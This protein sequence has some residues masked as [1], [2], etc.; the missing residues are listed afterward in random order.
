MENVTHTLTGLMLARAGLNRF[1]PHAAWIMAVA[2]N[3]P[4]IDIVSALG[5]ALNYLHWHRHFTHAIVTIPLTALLPVLVMRLFGPLPWMR[6][7]AIS[8]V[9]VA[10]H[11]LLDWTNIYGIRLLL[12][13]SDRWL[14][15]DVTNVVDFPI[16]V[17]LAVGSLWPLLSRLVSSEIG[18]RPGQ[19]RGLAIFALA[20]ILLYNCGR[21]VLHT[22]AVAMLESRTYDGSVPS[23]SAALP[24][25]I[26]PFRWTG[27]VETP[28]AFVVVPANLHGNFDPS[29]G[30]TLYKPEP[31]PA[32]DV[33]RNTDTIRRFLEF[34]QLPY[35]RLE[36]AAEP[37]N[38]VR[39][40][41]MDLRFGSPP[42]ERFVTEVL[43]G[44]DFKVIRSGFHFGA[45]RPSSWR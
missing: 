12:P 41:V 17:V 36:P 27:V 40:D 13:F 35:W 3:V 11:L 16:L 42:Q 7:W 24:H 21:G 45:V 20:F 5:G 37:E 1:T 25:F 4:D 33:A 44:P 2:A 23:R 18:A 32:L 30:R 9:G 28:Y 29:A 19:G 22:R 15:L 14:R 8:A 34:S 10:S 31:S 43:I 26:D 38:A 39:V 6:A